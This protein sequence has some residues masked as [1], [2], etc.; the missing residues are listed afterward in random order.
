MS[1][2]FSL[3]VFF[4]LHF[5][6]NLCLFCDCPR[7]R[8]VTGVTLQH[9]LNI[10]CFMCSRVSCRSEIWKIIVFF[11]V[12]K[13]NTWIKGRNQVVFFIYFHLFSLNT[14]VREA[15]R[16]NHLVKSAVTVV[17]MFK[18][19]QDSGAT[20]MHQI[21]SANTWSFGNTDKSQDLRE[22][23]LIRMWDR[24]DLRK[25]LFKRRSGSNAALRWAI[26]HFATWDQSWVCQQ[27]F[28]S[29][30]NW[31]INFGAAQLWSCGHQS[32]RMDHGFVSER[33]HKLRQTAH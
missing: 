22:L 15:L 32:E 11:T 24:A 21:F 25:G 12:F 17:Q 9:K 33:H 3:R 4:F 18:A 8:P 31:E 28:G 19:R 16:L 10:W 5:F 14:H 26:T 2:L 20:H 29:F 7:C 30:K 1:C 13:A 27:Y 23:L 6:S